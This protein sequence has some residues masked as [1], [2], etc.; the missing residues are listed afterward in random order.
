MKFNKNTINQITA[1]DLQGVVK[2]LNT[3][4]LAIQR[5]FEILQQI[6]DEDISISNNLML[7]DK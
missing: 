7:G 1:T 6:I 4:L 2:E 5:N 3:I